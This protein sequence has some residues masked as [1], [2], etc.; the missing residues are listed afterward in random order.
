VVDDQNAG[1]V[2]VREMPGDGGGSVALDQPFDVDTL[3]ELRKA[4]L[5]EAVA[6]GMPDDRATEVMF[7]VHELA[8]NAV[9]HGGGAGRAWMRVVA[10][11]LHCRVSDAGPGR[12]GGSVRRGGT[13]TGKP[14]PFER[15][16]GLWLVRNAADQVSV[17]S[18]LGGSQVTVVFALPGI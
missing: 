15:G 17:A 2:P 7:A 10:G 11:K 8:V 3:R 12:V 13:G 6:A 14:W 16:H 9:R 1:G 4:V 5:A 18:G